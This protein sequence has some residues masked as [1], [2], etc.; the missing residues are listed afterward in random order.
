MCLGRGVSRR[1]FCGRGFGGLVG[2]YAFYRV[3]ICI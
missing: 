1:F 3:W 2:L